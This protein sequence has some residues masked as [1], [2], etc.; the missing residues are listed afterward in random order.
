MEIP[1]CNANAL[2]TTETVSP[3]HGRVFPRN[4]RPAIVVASAKTPTNRTKR[5]TCVVAGTK[6]PPC[7][8]APVAV[9]THDT[10]H[11]SNEALRRISLRFLRKAS[12]AKS[13]I[14]H[15]PTGS[16]G[17]ALSRSCSNSS[18][19]RFTAA[20]VSTKS[21]SPVLGVYWTMYWTIY[22]QQST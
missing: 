11:D 10:H 12:F 3:H 6:D 5:Q 4:A 14:K 9:A 7:S 8:R 13:S 15:G 16:T 2:P 17:T 21:V 1:T 20:I 22:G 18:R 19:A